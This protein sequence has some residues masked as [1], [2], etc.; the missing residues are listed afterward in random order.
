MGAA[1]NNNWAILEAEGGRG[2]DDASSSQIPYS[3]SVVDTSLP[4]PLMIPRI[5]FVKPWRFLCFSL[6]LLVEFVFL[7]IVSCF[8]ESFVCDDVLTESYVKICSAIGE[9]LT[10]HSSRSRECLEASRT[11]VR[12]F[13]IIYVFHPE[14]ARII[15][16]F[17]GSAQGFCEGGR[18]RQRILNNSAALW[19]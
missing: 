10:I 11:Y 2:N 19:A 1:K 5:M 4:L 16:F 3:S 9:S 15:L 6:N 13:F 14:N 8:L 12:V 7:L 17:D 18:R